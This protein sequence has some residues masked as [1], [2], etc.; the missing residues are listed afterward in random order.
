MHPPCTAEPVTGLVTALPVEYIPEQP[1][2]KSAA[3]ATATTKMLRRPDF[4]AT[5]GGDV[6]FSVIGRHKKWLS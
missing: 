2:I 6:D 3:A 1:D 4:N 5:R